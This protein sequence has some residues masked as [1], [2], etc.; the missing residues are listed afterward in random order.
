MSGLWISDYID[1]G[2]FTGLFV[3]EL[4]WERPARGGRT[5]KVEVDGE[6]LQLS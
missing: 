4:G 3:E 5:V 6:S 1:K 2:D